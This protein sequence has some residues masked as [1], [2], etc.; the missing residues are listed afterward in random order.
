MQLSK[1]YGLKIYD[2][3]GEY[4]GDVKDVM[5]STE[6]G[7]IKYLLKAHPR[8]FLKKNRKESLEFMRKN[9]IPFSKVKSIGEII[10]IRG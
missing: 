2:E 10:I 7:E 5:I 4:V 6:S 3:S 9:L 8:A 1:I